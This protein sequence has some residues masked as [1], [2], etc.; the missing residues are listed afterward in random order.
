M[1][2]NQIYEDIFKDFK[3]SNDRVRVLKLDG[4]DTATMYYSGLRREATKG[5]GRSRTIDVLVKEC[6]VYLI[7]LD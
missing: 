2:S 1:S 5:Y 7:K 3:Q 4:F 6:K